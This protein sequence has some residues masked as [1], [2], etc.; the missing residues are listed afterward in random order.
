MARRS[1]KPFTAQSLYSFSQVTLV[2]TVEDLES[3]G[4]PV[5][6]VS[7]DNDPAPAVAIGH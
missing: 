2:R 4:I 1:G 5:Y 6:V 3:R 7:I